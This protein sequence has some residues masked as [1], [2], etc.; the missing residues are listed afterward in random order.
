MT[1]MS[2]TRLVRNLDALGIDLCIH[3]VSKLQFV[4]VCSNGDHQQL[5]T[6]IR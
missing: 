3:T 4:R 1:L 2:R 6:P 5:L